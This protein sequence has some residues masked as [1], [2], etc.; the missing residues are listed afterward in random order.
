M[1]VDHFFDQALMNQSVSVPRGACP[2]LPRSHRQIV[3]RGAG[4]G[5]FDTHTP[6]GLE[7]RNAGLLDWKD[8]AAPV[9]TGR[10]ISVVKE[11]MEDLP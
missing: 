7:S 10:A 6:P 2:L 8:A 4:A 3:V 11:R 1:R 9:G 5:A